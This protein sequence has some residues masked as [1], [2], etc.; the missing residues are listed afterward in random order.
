MVQQASIWNYIVLTYT[1]VKKLRYFGT[2][3][4][5]MEKMK[6][7]YI[8]ATHDEYRRGRRETMT[9]RGLSFGGYC[10]SFCFLGLAI[11]PTD[12]RYNEAQITGMVHLPECYNTSNTTNTT[13][14][15]IQG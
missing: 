8:V 3:S 11:T 13:T 4:N 9:D 12:L 1:T 5:V 15:R 14:L 10:G 6:F 7:T 2:L